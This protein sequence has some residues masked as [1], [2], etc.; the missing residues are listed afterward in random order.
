MITKYFKNGSRIQRFRPGG[1]S[2]DPDAIYVDFPDYSVKTDL[3]SSSGMERMPLGHGIVIAVD[4]KTG[5]TR[6]SEY[7]RYDKENKGIARRVSVPNLKVA[8]PGSPTNAE[9]DEYAKKLDQTYGHSGGTT[10]VFYVP[11]A[12]YGGMVKMMESAESG[13]K[14]GER[15]G[16]YYIDHDYR[17]SDHNCGTYGA[18]MIKKAMP[19]WKKALDVTTLGRIFGS[20]FP[21]Y[22][23]GNASMNTPLVLRWG[24]Y[25]R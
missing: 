9:L 3:P 6:G 24:S 10:R 11:G 15:K 5:N 2:P 17:I 18:T 16:H 19:W 1:A 21:Q 14:T 7:G 12:D 25:S 20:G 23:Y 22:T 4:E 13:S 8:N